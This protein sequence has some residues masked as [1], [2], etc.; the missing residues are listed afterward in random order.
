MDNKQLEEIRWYLLLLILFNLLLLTI[1]DSWVGVFGVVLI[2]L[3]HILFDDYF[4]T[5]RF[6]D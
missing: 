1:F 4:V 2:S 6:F 5:M 3:D